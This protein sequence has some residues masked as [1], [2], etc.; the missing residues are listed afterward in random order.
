MDDSAVPVFRIFVSLPGD[1][2]EE[3]ALAERVIAT[4]AARPLRAGQGG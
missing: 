3:R 1:V 2:A 4:R